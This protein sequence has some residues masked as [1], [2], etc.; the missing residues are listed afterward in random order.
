MGHQITSSTGKERQTQTLGSWPYAS[1]YRCTQQPTQATSVSTHS[2]CVGTRNAPVPGASGDRGNARRQPNNPLP[3]ASGARPFPCALPSSFPSFPSSSFFFLS[4]FY[5][6]LY[7]HFCSA[8]YGRPRSPL[9]VLSTLMGPDLRPRLWLTATRARRRGNT[10]DPLTPGLQKG[11]ASAH[12]G[13]SG[14]GPGRARGHR[15]GTTPILR[16][17]P[18]N[19]TTPRSP[20]GTWR[21]ALSR[22]RQGRAPPGGGT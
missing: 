2:G 10:R 22:A 4:P 3:E 11:G 19:A 14:A 8:A 7:P 12:Q 20:S 17:A 13:P 21:P 1:A 9:F 6:S 5:P 15:E 18:R 16:P